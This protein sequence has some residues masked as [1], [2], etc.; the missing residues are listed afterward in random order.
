VEALLLPKSSVDPTFAADAIR[1]GSHSAPAAA[2]SRMS[3][4][5]LANLLAKAALFALLLFAVLRPDLPQFTGKAMEWRLLT[6]GLAAVAVPLVWL[7]V[8]SA[9]RAGRRYPHLVDLLVVTPFLLDTAGNALNLYDSIIWFDDV[10]HFVTWVPWVMA[11]GIAL[12][13]ARAI[14]RWAHFGVVIA[15]GAVTHILW[16]IAE[17]LTFIRFNP[18]E[19]RTAYTDTLGDLALSLSGTFVAALLVVT[20]L[21][22]RLRSMRERSA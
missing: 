22:K 21:W 18:T 11:F 6:Y 4:L 12:G 13:Y 15:F 2:A 17:Y 9:R 19:F 20:L 14:P 1:A 8:G 7:L 3:F 16:E 5:R 10:M